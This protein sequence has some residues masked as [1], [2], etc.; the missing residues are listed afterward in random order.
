MLRNTIYATL[1]LSSALK[2]QQTFP[3]PNV[4]PVPQVQAP[5][6]FSH[7]LCTLSLWRKIMKR[8]AILV[9]ILYSC[10]AALVCAQQQKASK[11]LAG[12]TAVRVEPFTVENSQ[13]TKDF[14]AGEEANLQLSTVV[15]LRT[16][17]IFETVI[18]GSQKSPDQPPASASSANTGPRT[19]ILSVTI[20]G[21]N[22]GSSSA[23]FLTWPLPV[24]TSE[25]RATFVFRD[26]ADSQEICRFEKVAKFRALASG[27][28]ASKE[29][30][31]SHM[32]GGLVDALVKEIQNKR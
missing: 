17:G 23:R 1:N 29:E 9:W 28:I 14:P 20:V 15:R 32:K 2:A 19:L 5:P 4:P 26:A 12:Y 10:F 6:R 21:F 11:P 22:K 7:R 16:S 25:V 3:F 8:S 13:S 27:G 30:Q 24:G 31:M 18:D